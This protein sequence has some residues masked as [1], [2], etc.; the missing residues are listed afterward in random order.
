M[1]V[2]QETGKVE[3]KCSEGRILPGKRPHPL[4]QPDGSYDPAICSRYDTIMTQ[5]QTLEKNSKVLLS[6]Q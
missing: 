2:D 6:L 3:F 4:K 5:M 1:S